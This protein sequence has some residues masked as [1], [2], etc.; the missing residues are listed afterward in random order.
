MT[1]AQLDEELNRQQIVEDSAEQKALRHLLLAQQLLA[2][3]RSDDAKE[4]LKQAQDLT[5]TTEP[6]R[7]LM[8][9]AMLLLGDAKGADAVLT[10]LQGT[11]RPGE[12]AL[13]RGWSATVQER[14]K[15]AR[16]CLLEAQ[17]QP[18]DPAGRAECQYWQGIIYQHDG[19][20]PH[21]AEAFRKA[22]ESSAAAK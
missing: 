8:A 14:W 20:F 19:D 22:Y 21:A 16:G 13:L 4:Q 12:L 11:S 3:G 2:S 17:N 9:R 10:T 7:M 6:V 1:R 15:E 5:P 18:L